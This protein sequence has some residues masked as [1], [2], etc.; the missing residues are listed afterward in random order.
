[1]QHRYIENV[2]RISEIFKD[3]PVEPMDNAVYW[4]EYILRYKGKMLFKLFKK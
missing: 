1:M 3:R 2:Q 4:I